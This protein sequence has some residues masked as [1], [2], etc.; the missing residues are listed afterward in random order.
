VAQYLKLY[1]ADPAQI[2]QTRMLLAR[3]EVAIDDL[4]T[5]RADLDHTLKELRKIR[6]A[7]IEHLGM[8]G[9]DARAKCKS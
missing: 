1:D 7:C 6:A 8:E 2:A 9:S 5:K 4:Q 3:I